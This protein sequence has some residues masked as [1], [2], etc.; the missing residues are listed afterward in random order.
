MESGKVWG[1]ILLCFA[2]CCIVSNV[3]VAQSLAVTDISVSPSEVW[4]N[5]NPNMITISAKCVLGGSIVQ[6]ADM[7]AQV[8]F[9]RSGGTSTGQT[10]TGTYSYKLYTS[11]PDSGT[12]TVVVFCSHAGQTASSSTAFVAH[13]L[14]LLADYGKEV[15]TYIGD[16]MVLDVKFKLDGGLITPKKDTFSV[17]LG[18]GSRWE[19][20]EQTEDPILNNSYQRIKLKIPLY[21]SRIAKGLYDLRIEAKYGEQV[22]SVEKIQFV[23]VNNPLEIYIQDPE[24][25]HIVGSNTSK[26][27][28]AKV[29][30]KAGSLWDLDVEN[31]RV[32]LFNTDQ[33]KDLTLRRMF[34]DRIS[35]ICI[36]SVNLPSMSPGMYSLEITVAYP[37]MDSARYTAKDVVPL[38]EALLL[39]GSVKDAKGNVIQTSI[40][41]ENVETGDL[42]EVRTSQLG[43]Y[44]MNLLPGNY[45][46]VFRFTGGAIVEVSNISIS[47]SELITL[48]GELIRYDE[49]HIA[50]E[51]PAGMKLVK[52]M[53]L[54]IALPF[55]GAKIYMPYDSSLMTGDEKKLKVYVCERWNFERSVCAGSWRII[56]DLAVYTIKD[57]VEFNTSTYGSF[58]L[59]EN[60]KLSFS[61]VALD[62]KE[63]YMKDSIVISGMVVNIKKEAVHGATI[64][65]SFP[66]Q[67]VSSSATT[68]ST[69]EFKLSINAP[70]VEGDYDLIV[71]AAKD[72]FIGT[73]S[74]FKVTISKKKDVSLINIPDIV[75]VSMDEINDIEFKLINSGQMELEE[76]IYVHISGISTDW[77]ELLPTYV[78]TLKVGEEKSIVIRVRLN[79]KLCGG[80]CNK[81]YL[82]NVEAK[83]REVSKTASFTMKLPIVSSNESESTETTQADSSNVPG[84][85]G[86][87]LSA[88]NLSS[89]YIPL[90]VIVVLLILIVNKKK[91]PT[92]TTFGRKHKQGQQLRESTINKL[93]RII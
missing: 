19:K 78:P 1:W 44:S 13:R 59:G 11:F 50:S 71:S 89:P 27:I 52:V 14:E 25:V 62:N 24:I 28:T 18:S 76:P 31:V 29:V 67:G 56:D 48:P 82:V 39:S 90:T 79:E 10:T 92:G 36:F 73:N 30:F 46:F 72:L 84:L 86:F 47:K 42:S 35:S 88:P 23:W 7:W 51:I 64:T 93:R 12:Y 55:A 33:S 53:V 37:S 21:S 5:K 70:E 40:S 4:V 69:G 57:A 60:D 85:T 8:Y 41:V 45:N 16:S 58:M 83:S 49:G 17:Y 15:E 61:E 43:N 66:A 32:R 34:C 87:A 6:N 38:R 20:L 65:A 22:L 3:S 9:P 26:N 77:Y 2:L 81:F 63:V 80:K 91:N 68:S 54:E 74:S 75:P